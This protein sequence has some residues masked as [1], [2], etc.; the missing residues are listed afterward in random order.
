MGHGHLLLPNHSSQPVHWQPNH[1]HVVCRIDANAFGAK[2]AVST[3]TI[4]ECTHRIPRTH[5]PHSSCKPCSS[6]TDALCPCI[7]LHAASAACRQSVP[8]SQAHCVPASSCM[9][10][11]QP[12]DSPCF[13]QTHCPPASFCMLLLQ[14]AD[15]PFPTHRRTVSLHPPACCCYSLQTVRV[16]LTDTLSPCIL[17]MLL[18][19]PADSPCFTHGR[20]VSLHPPACCFCSLQTVRVSI[21]DA[22]CPCILLHAAAAAC[23][24]SVFHSQ[25]H[26]PPASSACC[27]CR[28][29]L[30]LVTGAASGLCFYTSPAAAGS[31]YGTWTAAGTG[32][33]P[34]ATD[35]CRGATPAGT[36]VSN[37]GEGVS[38][39][40]CGCCG[41][42]SR[43]G[44]LARVVRHGAD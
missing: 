10:L 21:T 37:V 9:L 29:G 15:S 6:L 44:E 42:I 11:L 7:L 12:A 19:Q 20:I 38:G 43:R 32:V 33:P 39:Y 36:P 31:V 3:G 16:S 28:W 5:S 1:H 8:H 26:C 22:V 17:C 30:G 40:S 25:T 34:A 18:L 2:L 24:Q 27:C 4:T 13:T 41:V 35:E 23:R 14:P